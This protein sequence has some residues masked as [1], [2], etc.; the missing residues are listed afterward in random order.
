MSQKIS[1][2]QRQ[3]KLLYQIV[4]IKSI[5]HNLSTNRNNHSVD[6]SNVNSSGKRPL[7]QKLHMYA[8]M[9]MYIRLDDLAPVKIKRNDWLLADTCPQA[10]NHCDFFEFEKELK[11]YKSRGLASY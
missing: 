8:V 3:L 9:Y 6:S 10:A 1:F 4:V 2:W 11:F 7:L 5:Y